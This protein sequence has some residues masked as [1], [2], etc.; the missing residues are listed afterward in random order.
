MARNRN[1]VGRDD[2]DALVGWLIGVMIVI[3]IVMMIVMFICTVG[4][5]V[6]AFYALRSYCSSFKENVIDSNMVPQ[7]A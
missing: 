3:A 5:L 6:G 1:V 7:A 4:S 2:D